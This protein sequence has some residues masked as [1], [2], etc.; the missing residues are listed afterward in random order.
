[1]IV[2]ETDQENVNSDSGIN[3]FSLYLTQHRGSRV[4][5]CV[6]VCLGFEWTTCKKN[7]I[8]SKQYNLPYL[9]KEQENNV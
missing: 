6:G 1:M 7:T 8:Q 3:Y 2:Y 5:A 9:K 4:G